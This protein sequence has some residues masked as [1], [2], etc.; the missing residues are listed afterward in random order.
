MKPFTGRID[1]CINSLRDLEQTLVRIKN[2][3]EQETYNVK[4]NSLE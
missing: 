3:I 4:P 1:L 2:I